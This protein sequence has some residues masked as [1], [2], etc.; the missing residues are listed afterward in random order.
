MATGPAGRKRA[1]GSSVSTPHALGSSASGSGHQHGPDPR[2]ECELGLA[3]TEAQPDHI[4]LPGH[5]AGGPAWD[6]A[7][8]GE[9][10]S[11]PPLCPAPEGCCLCA[12]PARLEGG[13]TCWALSCSPG[14]LGGPLMPHP[15]LQPTPG[16]IG[17]PQSHPGRHGKGIRVLPPS[18]HVM[19]TLS[20]GHSP[21]GTRQGFLLCSPGLG[22]SC[23]GPAGFRHHFLSPSRRRSQKMQQSKGKDRLEGL[24]KTGRDVIHRW[25]D[26]LQRDPRA[27][28]RQLVG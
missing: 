27:R 17:A 6:R 16:Q 14:S 26:C 5:T 2:A 15:D 23:T 12:G 8:K 11:S 1:Q 24:L 7:A 25:Y 4:C 18:P 3:L 13:P 10:L 9:G 19:D 28:L 20:N 21:T 22:S